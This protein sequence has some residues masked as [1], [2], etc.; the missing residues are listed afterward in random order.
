MKV[1]TGSARDAA[2]DRWCDT[3]WTAFGDSRVAI[4]QIAQGERY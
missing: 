1:P 3:V 2:I 4:I